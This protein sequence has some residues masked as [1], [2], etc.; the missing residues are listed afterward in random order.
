MNKFR[1]TR[2][3]I[4][5]YKYTFTNTLLEIHVYKYNFTKFNNEPFFPE[6]KNKEIKAIIKK[7]D[8]NTVVGNYINTMNTTFDLNFNSYK[9]NKQ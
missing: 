1:N 5:F 8:Y 9:A 6:R 7:Y 2:L 4:Q 3:Q